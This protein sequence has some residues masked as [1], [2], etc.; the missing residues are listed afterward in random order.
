MVTVL[1][2]ISLIALI[3][4]TIQETRQSDTRKLLPSLFIFPIYE[5]SPKLNDISIQIRNEGIIALV[6]IAA[7]CMVWGFIAALLIEPA[8]VGWIFLSGGSL[9]FLLIAL[10]AYFKPLIAFWRNF[11]VVLD[12]P[13]VIDLARETALASQLGADGGAFN[14][15][16]EDADIDVDQTQALN[17]A[18]QTTEDESFKILKRLQLYWSDYKQQQQQQQQQ[19]HAKRQCRQQNCATHMRWCCAHFRPLL[20]VSF[21]FLPL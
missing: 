15:A 20:V 21:C 13:T 11:I 16:T 5:Y 17:D 4:Y 2:I 8:F 6:L 19:Q 12:S 10:E 18:N 7:A 14:D 1:W 9:M 3:A